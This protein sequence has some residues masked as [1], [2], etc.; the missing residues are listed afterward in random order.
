MNKKIW[1]LIGVILIVVSG[2]GTYFAIEN[3]TP[4]NKIT[5]LVNSVIDQQAILGQFTIPGKVLYY[6]TVTV[7]H[8]GSGTFSLNPDYFYAI[9]SNG[10]YQAYST[11]ISPYPGYSPLSDL[12]L[13][14][15]QTATGGVDVQ[16]PTG[17]TITG[18]QYEDSSGKVL[19]KTNEVSASTVFLSQITFISP[20]SSNSQVFFP[21][22][23][24]NG[25]NC[26]EGHPFTI[27]LSIDAFTSGLQATSIQLGTGFVLISVNPS[28]PYVLGSNSVLSLRISPPSFSYNGPLY[29]NV[30]VR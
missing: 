27:D 7:D 18:F 17:S 9:T 8:T 2:T 15:S 28:L 5:L 24:A 29:V 3:L 16:V 23:P 21:Y 12:Q 26:L 1:A 10:Q 22:D 13:V 14:K 11:T 4:Q 19:A 25:V 6:V 30:T 20:A